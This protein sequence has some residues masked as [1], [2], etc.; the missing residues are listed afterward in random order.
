[1][2]A[3]SQHRRPLVAVD[4]GNSRTKLGLFVPPDQS[5]LPV[6]QRMFAWATPLADRRI[7]RLAQRP[8]Q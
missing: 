6:P 4:V 3:P 2:Q 5:P 7:G 1:M 8:A